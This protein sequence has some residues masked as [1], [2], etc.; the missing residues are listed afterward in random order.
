MILLLNKLQIKHIAAFEHIKCWRE[1]VGVKNKERQGEK[2]KQSTYSV[3]KERRLRSF[4]E[5]VSL[6]HKQRL[7]KEA[8]A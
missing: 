8:D 6:K 5:F 3:K 2:L 7:K 4:I 1:I